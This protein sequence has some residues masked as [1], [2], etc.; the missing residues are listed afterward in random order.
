MTSV[1][2]LLLLAI[3]PAFL[4]AESKT[5]SLGFTGA[6]TDHGGQNC[7]TCHNQFGA[8]NSD[9]AGSLQ[10]SVDDYI[11]TEVQTIRIIVQHPQAARFGFQVTIREESDETV[12][13]GLF[14]P[15]PASDPVQV[16]CDD[17]SQ[18][19]SPGPCN[20]TILRQFAEHYER[21][22]EALPERRSNLMF[23]G[24]H[25]PRK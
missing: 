1:R 2:S 16:A 25:P 13:A 15:C 6:P 21:S 24:R 22:A 20:G 8:A 5:P 12:S 17:G 11:P 7:S 10:V 23:P 18:F 19:G 4:L 3:A 14:R 9:K